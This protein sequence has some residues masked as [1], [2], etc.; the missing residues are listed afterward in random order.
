LLLASTFPAHA[1]VRTPTAQPLAN[2]GVVQTST[3]FTV[4][5][6]HAEGGLGRVHRARDEQLGRTVF[7]HLLGQ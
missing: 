7:E 4:L 3:G 5:G 2:P 1:E 6:P